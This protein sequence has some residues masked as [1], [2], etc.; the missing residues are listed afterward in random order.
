SALHVFTYS[1]RPGTLAANIKAL[2]NSAEKSERSRRLHTLSDQKKEA[3]YKQMLGSNMPV[4]WE[5]EKEAPFMYGFTPNYI[6]V[7][8]PYESNKSNAIEWHILESMERDHDK[9]WI[10]Y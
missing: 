3:F 10:C 2:S 5:A 1:S 7:K 8:A 6:K 9:D 4:L